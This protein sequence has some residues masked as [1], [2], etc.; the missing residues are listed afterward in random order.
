[1][2]AK[3]YGVWRGLALL[4]LL[5]VVGGCASINMSRVG[6][7]MV[8]VE[9]TNWQ[10]FNFIPLASG[11]TDRPNENDCLFLRDSVT[12][13]NNIEMVDYAVQKYGA[14]GVRDIVSYTTDEY[15]LFILLKH[16]SMHTSA[17][18]VMPGDATRQGE[19]QK[20]ESLKMKEEKLAENPSPEMLENLEPPKKPDDRKDEGLLK[21]LEF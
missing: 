2:M 14:V 18:L 10:L 16:H 19:V 5:G 6:K 8:D 1:M 21:I 12:L 3:I 20:L 15:I 4:A 11:N 13:E 17:E 9:N 7:V